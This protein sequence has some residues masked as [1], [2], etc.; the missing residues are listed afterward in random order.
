MTASGC[1]AARLDVKRIRIDVQLPQRLALWPWEPAESRDVV[2]GGFRCLR[3]H[4]WVP[5]RPESGFQR[6]VGIR[7]RD[8]ADVPF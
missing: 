6:G 7:T 5:R 4:V 1:V 3:R 8:D 2:N